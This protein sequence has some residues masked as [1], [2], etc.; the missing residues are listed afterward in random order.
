LE[1]YQILEGNIRY[2]TVINAKKLFSDKFKALIV[3]DFAVVSIKDSLVIYMLVETRGIIIVEV[4]WSKD[5]VT[6]LMKDVG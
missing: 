1:I 3:N 4:K 6:L 5:L 2:L